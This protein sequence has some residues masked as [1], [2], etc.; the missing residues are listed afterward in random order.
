MHYLVLGAN[1]YIGSYLYMRLL[2]DGN[3]VTGTR[4]IHNGNKNCFYFDILKNDLS[5]IIVKMEGKEKVAIICI[6]QANIDWCFE[7]YEM[8]YEINVN[9]TINLIHSLRENGFYIICFSTDNVFDG[10]EGNYSE[11]SKTHGI[12]RYGIMKEELEQFILKKNFQEVC[13]LRIS[14]VVSSKQEKQNIFFEWER[15]KETG[16]IRCIKGNKLSFVSIEDIYQ[17]CL[18]LSKKRLGG[19][20]NIVGDRA[21]SRAELAKKFCQKSGYDKVKIEECGVGEFSF[22]DNRPL[23]ISMSNLK[24]KKETGYMFTSMDQVIEEYLENKMIG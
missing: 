13:I 23:N 24:F 21:Y 5:D 20:F 12:N 8:A 11:Y 16:L 9:R 18:I 17:A 15:Q 1:G 14:K 3:E 22:K 7:N 6:A 2:M 4:H 19:L 10:K